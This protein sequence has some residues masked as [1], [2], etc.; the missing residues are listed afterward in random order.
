MQSMRGGCVQRSL[1]G[2]VLL[3]WAH[4]S[5]D[6]YTRQEHLVRDF[7]ACHLDAVTKEIALKELWNDLYTGTKYIKLWSGLGWEGL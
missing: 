6:I 5:S 2:L 1:F 4:A 3:C 7:C